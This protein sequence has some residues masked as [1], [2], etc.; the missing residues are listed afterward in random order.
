MEIDD[1]QKTIYSY[2]WTLRVKQ[3][4]FTLTAPTLT[5]EQQQ[6]TFIMDPHNPNQSALQL[7]IEL[8]NW[9]GALVTSCPS[10]S[11]TFLSVLEDGSL[12]DQ[13]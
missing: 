13:T 5:P 2:N 7:T 8:P 6:F 4:P 3:C 10:Y 1:A 9:A 11:L 12:I